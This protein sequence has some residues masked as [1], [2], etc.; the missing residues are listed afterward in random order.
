[1]TLTSAGKLLLGTASAGG[2][3]LRISGLPTS[4]TGLSSGDVW[5]NGGVLTIVP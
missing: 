2:S 4:S 5:S 3:K 1:M